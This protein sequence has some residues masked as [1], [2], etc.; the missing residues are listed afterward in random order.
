MPA[1]PFTP[2]AAES[3]LPRPGATAPPPLRVLIVD[4]SEDDAFLVARELRRELGAVES[5]RV[6]TAEAMTQALGEAAWDVVIADHHMPRFSSVRAL[7]VLRSSGL[8]IPFVIY[9]GDLEQDLGIRAM[10]GGASDFVEKGT[11]QR[12]IAVIRRELEHARTRRAKEHAEQSVVR[13]VNYDG[14]TGLPN[15]SLFMELL[16]RRLAEQAPRA[17]GA[18]LF[19]DLDRFMRVNDS[20]GYVTGDALIRQVADRLR[21]IA[22][23]GDLVARLGQDEFAIFVGAADPAAGAAAAERVMQR[24]ADAFVQDGQEF[25]LTCSIGISLFPGDAADP[26]SLIKNAESAMFAAKTR[27]RNNVQPYRPELNTGSSRRLRLES[28]LRSA[29]E[30]NQLF[31]VYQ[32]IVDVRSGATV[33]AEA[34]LRWRHPDL[35]L[36]PPDEFI[37]LADESGQII[38][39]GEWV[40]HSACAQMQRWRDASGLDLFVAVNFSAVQFRQ[41][42]L[43]EQ[44][45]AVLAAT[46]LPPAALEI[47][48]TETV[49]MEDAKATVRTLEALHGM[50]MRVSIDDFGTGYSS[51]AYLK[52]FPIDVLK[53]DKSFVRDIGV[54]PDQAAIARTVAALGRSLKLLTHAEGVENEE[55]ARFLATEGCDRIQG[56]W[57]S[58]PLEVRDFQARIAREAAGGEPR[59]LRG[60]A[61]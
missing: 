19:L 2:A 60:A 26:D 51:L 3:T 22:G 23:A 41:E 44:I 18:L 56:F 7:E 34:L 32:P 48:I 28:D 36:V 1:S 27:G 58:R 5:I 37:G 16:Q 54:D 24:F 39:I 55:Q 17:A 45:A 50:R 30:R 57:I 12:L 4:D 42:N 47:E 38:P 43:R 11:P 15:R 40:L 33:G 20:F 35:G 46:G 13:L 61:A 29:V 6:D 21:A 8:E 31:L 25:F 52:R 14:L 9:S 59:G 53:I 10:Y 49:A